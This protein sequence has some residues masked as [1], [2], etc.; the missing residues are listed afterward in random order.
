MFDLKKRFL[1]CMEISWVPML[2][3]MGA[4]LLHF[5]WLYLFVIKWQLEVLGLGIATAAT[6]LTMLVMV[7]IYSHCFLPR[8]K[9]S[10]FCPG[11][12]V[13]ENWG[14]YFKL[15]VPATVMW[16]A[17]FWAFEIMVLLSGVIGIKEQAAM[18]IMFQVVSETYMIN[19]GLQEASAALIGNQIGAV[20][21]P[22][23]KR[24][25][26]VIFCLCLTSGI[27]ISILLFKYNTVLIK[28][29]TEDQILIDL[30]KTVFGVLCYGV[31]IDGM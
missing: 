31:V 20:N 8:I 2:A 3:Q 5:L 11:R 7:E 18:V 30:S 21:V 4:T 17:E 6:Y 28:L 14:E 19:M 27:I 12:E 25:H 1:N 9:V 26:K 29:F 16:C 23:A 10:L 24:Y 15:G 22:L 13:F